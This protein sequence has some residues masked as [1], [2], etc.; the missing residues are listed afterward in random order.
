M[1][2]AAAT[3]SSATTANN[4]ASCRIDETILNEESIKDMDNIALSFFASLCGKN[5]GAF[6][7]DPPDGHTYGCLELPTNIAELIG[8]GGNLSVVDLK[9]ANSIRE[10]YEGGNITATET[11]SL[12]NFMV[13]RVYQSTPDSESDLYACDV[14]GLAKL[15]CDHQ[16]KKET[17]RSDGQPIRSVTLKGLLEESQIYT[18]N[19]FTEMVDLAGLNTVQ[20][21][22]PTSI[23]AAAEN[24]VTD[25]KMQLLSS[26]LTDIETSGGLMVILSLSA[27]TADDDLNAVMAAAEY[28]VNRK[29]VLA[30]TLP[31]ETTN[32][33]Q[34]IDAI[35]AQVGS[36]L[37]LFVPV[38][39]VDLGNSD[40]I[41]N[42]P[43]VYGSLEWSHTTTVADIASSTSQEDR[44]KLFYHEAVACIMRSPLEHAACYQDMPLFWSFGFDLNI[45]DCMSK[46][47]TSFLDYGQ[48]GRFHETIDSDWWGQHRKSL[49]AR[50]VYVSEQGLG[51]SFTSWKTSDDDDDGIII[52]A[53]AKLA[54]LR[55]VVRSGLFPNS[56][57]NVDGAC[58]NTPENDFILGD[59]TLSP[60]QSPPP[61]CGNGWWNYGTSQCDYWVP[62]PEPTPSPTVPCPVCEECPVWHHPHPNAPSLFAAFFAGALVMLLFSSIFRNKKRS[63]YSAIPDE[64][65]I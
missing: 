44:S 61:D 33:K 34:I 12:L 30:L 40:S 62:P 46:D 47:D 21:V 25:K 13:D 8:F 4:K 50:Q 24:T 45:D 9:D 64:N 35:R 1:T 14:N 58:L 59:D 19:D 52:D 60:T 38:G 3:S 54:A 57:T 15:S 39:E 26:T 55:D 20:I 18:T 2:S 5:R 48:C 22:V 56:T 29:V 53:P 10:Q 43:K 27:D 16:N 42:D 23:F 28:A 17:P 7:L 11:L 37:P 6:V 49:A 32:P 65:N 51:W 63:E 41:I 31:R 36:D